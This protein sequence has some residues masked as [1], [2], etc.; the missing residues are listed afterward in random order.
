MMQKQISAIQV[1]LVRGLKVLLSPFRFRGKGTILLRICPKNVEVGIS[2]FGYSF[3]C[4]LSEHIQRSIFLFNYDEYAELFIRKILKP[5]DTFLDIGAN[6]GFYT[7][8]AASIV[9]DTGQVIAIEPNP[10]IYS[11]LI[12][13]I[14]VNNIKNVLSLNIALGRD[15]GYLN[16]Y[17]SPEAGNDSAT[18]IAHD[19]SA[20]IKVEVLS[21]DEIA[22]I[23]NIDKI[24]YLK[25]DVDGF[26]PDVFVGAK[27]LLAEGRID[28][29]QSEFCDY[30][31]RENSSSPEM[32]HDFLTG[33]GF[34]DVEGSPEFVKNCIVD[35]FF[36]RR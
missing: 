2:L 33:S 36:I 8:L 34:R 32:L 10:K 7:L 26:E 4:D 30:W 16:L 28:A 14:K 19:A 15:K 5:G 18:M 21:L 1:A 12:N 25:I 17:S 23:H 22:S 20:I 3:R 13:T 31:L 6:V 29:I 27:T 9:G 35:R 24:N 11:K